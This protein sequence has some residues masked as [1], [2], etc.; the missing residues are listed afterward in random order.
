MK[1]RYRYFKIAGTIGH[2]RLIWLISATLIV[3]F[4]LISTANAIPAFARKYQAEC[5]T[6][7]NNWPA[8]NATGRKFKEQGYRMSRAEE[9]GFLNWDKTLPVTA[10]IKARPYEKEDNGDKKIRA[11]HEV[12][13]MIGGVM[14]KDISGFFELE[15]EDDNDFNVE[16]GSASIAYHPMDALNVQFSWGAITWNDPYDVYS[17]ARKLTRNRASVINERFGGADNNGRVRDS[18]Q[19]VTL[20][21]RPKEMI[22]YSIGISGL[23]DDSNGEDSDVINGR[24]AWDIK[25]NIMVGLTAMSGSCE[26]TASN[27]AVKRDFTR[28]GIDAQA[29]FDNI[30]VMG[31]LLSAKD[32]NAAGT[33]EDENLALYVE[34]S[35]AFK[36]DGRTTFVPLLRLDSYERNDGKDDF[37]ELTAQVS[38]YLTQN[39]RGFI[40]FWNQDAPGSGNNN[41]MLTLQGEV[42]F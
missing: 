6:C 42:T 14:A 33:N 28:V 21:G 7:H 22:Y 16:V 37:T 11:L 32:D 26:N 41:N 1:M 9:Q 25:Q 23:A 27:C 31:A 3:N 2:S 35:Y 39:A 38:Y 20:Y 30:R 18:R 8:L 13:I 17:N 40:E 36:K 12:E 34:A 15:A 10:M 19:N 4:F 24:L 29:D 5:S